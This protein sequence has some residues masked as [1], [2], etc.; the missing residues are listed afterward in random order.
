MKEK[1]ESCFSDFHVRCLLNRWEGQN[2]ED[3]VNA[4]WEAAESKE[5]F[6]R[7]LQTDEQL[8]YTQACGELSK[9]DFYF[10]RDMI[11]DR[12]FKTESDA[13]GVR[14]MHDGF[15]VIIP[16]GRGDGESRVAVFAKD[17]P[18][19]ERTLE[20]FTLIDGDFEISGYDCADEPIRHLHGR[21]QVYYGNSFVVFVES[22]AWAEQA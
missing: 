15:R 2:D 16:N 18:F 5:A 17:E 12:Q 3:K 22:P 11:G 14:V 19:N 21:Y 6:I 10:I 8:R 1:L 9:G 20:Y 7:A 13:G 4:L